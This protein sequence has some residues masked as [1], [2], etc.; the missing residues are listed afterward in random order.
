M[1]EKLT[2]LIHDMLEFT[3]DLYV[4]ARFENQEYEFLSG[5]FTPNPLFF[6]NCNAFNHY[7]MIKCAEIRFPELSVS[8]ILEKK[9]CEL[10][11]Y[12]EILEDIHPHVKYVQL[13]AIINDMSGLYFSETIAHESSDFTIPNLLSIIRASHE[14]DY[15]PGNFAAEILEAS[16]IEEASNMHF[17]AA[18]D[19]FITQDLGIKNFHIPSYGY[20]SDLKI[21]NQ[22]KDLVHDGYNLENIKAE[23]VKGSL[24]ISNPDS[25]FDFIE[26]LNNSEYKEILSTMRPIH[27][28]FTQE[29]DYY[30]TTVYDLDDNNFVEAHF[31]NCD[32]KSFQDIENQITAV[33]FE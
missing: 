1:R 25:Y 28:Y 2:N 30:Q 11:P 13:K 31:K 15:D 19:L 9:L 32:F 14:N 16:L 7:M 23:S 12:S 21:M 18:F 4:Y 10:F 17:S 29:E 3:N 8:E 6:Y 24:L 26:Y 22:F 27:D 33:V 20:L 5:S